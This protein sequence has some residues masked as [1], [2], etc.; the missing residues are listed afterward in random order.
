MA[1]A[2][3]FR[4]LPVVAKCAIIG[5]GSRKMIVTIAKAVE[6]RGWP[7]VGALDGKVYA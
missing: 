4:A 6:Y 1:C 2:S 5:S 3:F 7:T